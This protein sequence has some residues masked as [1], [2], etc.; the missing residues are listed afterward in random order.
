MAGD[1]RLKKE[2]DTGQ[3]LIEVVVP[4]PLAVHRVRRRSS[5]RR[6]RPCAGTDS[7]ARGRPMLASPDQCARR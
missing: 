5:E 7:C 2:R 6:P 1:A 4:F 3:G